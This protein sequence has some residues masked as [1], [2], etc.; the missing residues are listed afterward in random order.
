MYILNVK[1]FL[2]KFFSPWVFGLIAWHSGKSQHNGVEVGHEKQQQ[3]KWIYEA[4]K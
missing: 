4:H 3:V 1:E 2:K